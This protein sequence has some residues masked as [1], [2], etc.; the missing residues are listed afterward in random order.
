MYLGK[1]SSIYSFLNFIAIKNFKQQT[2]PIK[3]SNQN[4]RLLETILYITV[5]N[6]LKARL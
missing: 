6:L 5:V 3:F 4:V 2:I 1:I